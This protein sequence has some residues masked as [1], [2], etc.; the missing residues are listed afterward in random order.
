MQGWRKRFDRQPFVGERWVLKLSIILSV[1]KVTQGILQLQYFI[2]FF[3][4]YSSP[5]DKAYPL[6][7]GSSSIPVYCHMTSLG[8]CGDGGWTL[9][10]KL[11]GSKVSIVEETKP[12]ITLLR[13]RLKEIC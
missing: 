13:N 2:N 10:M 7:L 1:S 11:D 8:A 4:S 5:S 12:A 9:V 3:F 6:K